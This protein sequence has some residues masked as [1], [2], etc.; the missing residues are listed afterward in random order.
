MDQKICFRRDPRTSITDSSNCSDY[1]GS[2]FD[3]GQLAPSGTKLTVS[4]CTWM[5]GCLH[6]MQK[7]HFMNF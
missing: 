2:G 1:A 7:S 5:H 3:Q 4:C 6:I